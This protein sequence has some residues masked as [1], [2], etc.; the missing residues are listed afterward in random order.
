M[1]HKSR[2]KEQII[3]EQMQRWRL[4]RIE[5][6]TE[7]RGIPIITVSR[8]PGSGGSIIAKNLADKL[9]FDLFHQEVL[10]EMAKS[11]NISEQLLKTL[12]EKGLSILEDWISSLVRDR[13]LWPDQYLKQLMKVIGAIGE[14]G[15]AIIVGRGANFILQPDNCIRVRIISPQKVRIQ[16]VTNSFKIPEDEAKRRVI[17]TESDRRAFIRKY[18]NAEI[19]DPVNYDIVIN[20]GTLNMDDVTSAIAAVIEVK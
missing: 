13:H 20:T 3:E 15:H 19:A 6:S 10:H 11:A 14:H 2:S 4:M 7:R 8:E 9:E 16:H 5:K 12:D 17:R 1:L 18:F